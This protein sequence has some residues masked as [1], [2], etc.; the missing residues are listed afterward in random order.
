MLRYGEEYEELPGFERYVSDNPF[1]AVGSGSAISYALLKRKADAVARSASVGIATEVAK[2]DRFGSPELEDLSTV[3]RSLGNDLESLTAFRIMWPLG[4][5][6]VDSLVN[7]G[8]VSRADIQPE[9]LAQLLF[10]SSWYGFLEEEQPADAQDALRRWSELANESAFKERVVQLL[11]DEDRVTESA[12]AEVFESAVCAVTRHLLG[13][14]AR[15]AAQAW[16]RLDVETGTALTRAV[17]ESDFEESLIERVL[18]PIAE[19]A[20]R[21]KSEVGSLTEAAHQWRRGHAVGVP[22]PV[23]A[24]ARVGELLKGW[25]PAASSWL[26]AVHDWRAAMVERIVVAATEAIRHRNADVALNLLRLAREISIDP[27]QRKLLDAQIDRVQS[28]MSRSRD[29]SD[30]GT[31]LAGWLVWAAIG[32]IFV[33]VRSCAAGDG[34]HG[35]AYDTSPSS[36][37]SR[38]ESSWSDLGPSGSAFQPD[39]GAE[40]ASPEPDPALE[41]MQRQLEEETRRREE[42]AQRIE[43]LEEELRQLQEEIPELESGLQSDSEWLTWVQSNLEEVWDWLQTHEPNLYDMDE[44]R[45]YNGVVDRYESMRRQYDRALSAHEERVADYRKKVARHNRIVEV[46]NTER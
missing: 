40:T 18:E 15:A 13:R 31:R 37:S 16:D 34:G 35:S 33:V 36:Y 26:D 32:F 28:A 12:A 1:R 3:V 29:G 17:T 27:E 21:L 41:E 8:S 25:H 5:R 4:E 43:R 19:A 23:R 39:G 46:L 20:E 7:G 22:K 24:L 11:A 30:I 9:E 6:W 2:A 14:V 44:V 45:A 38:S 42:A 10:L